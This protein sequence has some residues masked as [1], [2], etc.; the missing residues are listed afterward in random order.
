MWKR[1]ANNV[2][3]ILN[4]RASIKPNADDLSNYFFKKSAIEVNIFIFMIYF[5]TLYVF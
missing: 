2:P 1:I 3:R 4:W 5:I